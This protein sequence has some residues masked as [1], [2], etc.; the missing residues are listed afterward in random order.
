MF[1]QTESTPNEDSLK[2][3][4]GVT[5]ME[6]GAAEFLDTRTALKSPLAIR[7]MG[8]EGVTGVFYGPDFVTVSKDADNTWAVLKPE[9]YSVLME[10][11]SSG[12][13]LFKSEEDRDSAGPQDTVISDTDSET[14]AMIKELLETRPTV[15][16]TTEVVPQHYHPVSSQDTSQRSIPARGRNN[17]SGY[18]L[19]HAPAL[20]REVSPPLRSTLSSPF[21]DRSKQHTPSHTRSQ[22][23]LSSPDLSPMLV[24]DVFSP[25]P[26][27]ASTSKSTPLKAPVP[28]RP[29]GSEMSR[30]RLQLAA[31]KAAHRDWS[32]ARRSDYLKQT[33]RPSA[34]LE[35]G[36]DTDDALV[37]DGK[38]TANMGV[39][40]SPVKG[41][42]IGLFQ[43]TS[44]E[45]FEE[46]L[47]AS[48]YTPYGD[49]PAYTEAQTPPTAAIGKARATLSQPTMEW[50]QHETPA[51]KSPPMGRTGRG[52]RKH[53]GE[54]PPS[55]TESPTLKKRGAAAASGGR[56]KKSAR[57]TP[58]IPAKKV[59]KLLPVDESLPRSEEISKPN[60]LDTEFPWSTRAQ[61]RRE[62][63]QREHEEKMKCIE[64]FL[65]R[66]SDEESDDEDQSLGLTI[67]EEDD[68]PTTLRTGRGKM[69]PLKANPDAHSRDPQERVML[70][71]DPA[72][73]RAALLSKRSVRALAFRRRRRE[74]DSEIQIGEDEEVCVCKGMDDGR[75]LVQCDDCHTWY[76]LECIGI[77]SIQ[78]LGREEDPWYCEDCL[79]AEI[80]AYE[81]ASEPTFVPTDKPL[82]RNHR[83]PLMSSSSS[84]LSPF[85][86]WSMDAPI[87]RTPVHVRD[88]RSTFSSS[89]WAGSS[90]PSR[91]GPSTPGSSHT[92]RAYRTPT[93]FDPSDETSYA[94]STPSRLPQRGDGLF[95]TPKMSSASLWSTSGKIQKDNLDVTYR[96]HV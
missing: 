45:S 27:A 41:R 89:S 63:D 6:S 47:L 60:W 13:A 17:P 32:E 56:K 69:V 84:A 19:A 90:S 25:G 42:R 75:E 33:K 58:N 23:H 61:E 28:T 50:L 92:I 14:V 95:S 20:R 62:R 43:E 74:A 81:P 66:A 9:I 29:A 11:F 85:P 73:A 70:P 86:S 15:R 3:I 18:L 21:V 49:R 5:V 12:Q 35:D 93:I 51:Q 26:S 39:L 80:L 4:P 59:G 83:N 22:S 71:S 36:Y 82:S 65:D 72:D 16:K 53:P 30:I 88:V 79:G 8:V 78:E 31:E 48:G 24:D 96:K 87:P 1:I 68:G 77:R 38:S 91:G 44:E 52:H 40:E 10:F 46:S 54:R 64:R 2:F 76:H 67:H 94:L 55:P 37:L 34:D 7:L 57:A